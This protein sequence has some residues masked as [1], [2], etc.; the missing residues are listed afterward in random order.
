MRRAVKFIV[1]DSETTNCE[2][3]EPNPLA[4][5]QRHLISSAPLTQHKKK[6]VLLDVQL[7]LYTVGSICVECSD[8]RRPLDLPLPVHFPLHAQHT[9]FIHGE[10]TRRYALSLNMYEVCTVYTIYQ[11]TP[12]VRGHPWVILAPWH[13]LLDRSVAWSPAT[14][15]KNSYLLLITSR[16]HATRRQTDVRSINRW[17]SYYWNKKITTKYMN[18]R[19]VSHS[20][21]AWPHR[22][23]RSCWY[24]ALPT[25][26]Q[27]WLKRRNIFY[28]LLQL[29]RKS[30]GWFTFSYSYFFYSY[31]L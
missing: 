17:S 31:L 25:P 4:L 28:L 7:L 23:R 29:G 18:L 24:P 21:E 19:L 16:M 1:S 2:Q 10:K 26:W 6:A 5:F 22:H 27:S 11:D 12:Y 13:V 14:P 30:A 8:A 3:F 20:R 9:T 15:H